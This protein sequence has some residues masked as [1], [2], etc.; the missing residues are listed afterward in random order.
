MEAAFVSLS[1]GVRPVAL[2]AALLADHPTSGAAGRAVP[3]DQVRARLIHPSCRPETRE[4]VWSEVVLRARG[5]GEPWTT[6]AVGFAVPGL[7]RVLARLPRLARVERAEVEQEVLAGLV[8]ELAVVDPADALL[9]RRLLRAAD[10]AGHRAVYRARTA[11]L[12]HAPLDDT[13]LEGLPAV[14]DCVLPAAGAE[15]EVRDEYTVLW[16]AV[17]Q[18]VVDRHG[19]DLIVRT[20]LDGEAINELAKERGVSPRTLFRQRSAAEA[21]LGEALC[22][23]SLRRPPS[24]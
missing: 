18:R 7:R 12:D 3:V 21:R 16:E 5:E 19:A 4:R 11:H 24:E 22:D 17:Q 13:T 8:G 10:R 14:P 1:R 6:V 9:V 15:G 20:R 23:G 2:P